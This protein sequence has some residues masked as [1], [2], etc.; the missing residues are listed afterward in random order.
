MDEDEEDDGLAAAI[1]LSLAMKKVEEVPIF[2]KK[3]SFQLYFC[4]L[5][6][7]PASDAQEQELQEFLTDLLDDVPAVGKDELDVNVTLSFWQKKYT[8]IHR[9]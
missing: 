3:F 1:A 4:Q 6:A 8:R 2:Q 7:Q 9:N 5:V